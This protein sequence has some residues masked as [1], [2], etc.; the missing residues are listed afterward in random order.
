[1]KMTKW[2]AVA[3]MLVM[4]VGC[5]NQEDQESQSGSQDQKLSGAVKIAGSSTVYPVAMAAAEEFSRIHPDVSVTVS[6][7]GSGGGFA[8]YF[9]PGKTDI[10]NASRPIKPSEMEAAKANG[11]E[12][13]ELRVGI[14]AMSMVAN[15]NADWVDSMTFEQLKRIW[16]PGNPPQR[17]NEVDPSWPDEEFELYGPAATSG[18][19]DYFTE[20]VIGKERAHRSD[21]N[22]TEHDNV[23]VQGIEGNPYALGYFGFAYYVGNKD[24]IKALAIDAGDGPVLPSLANAQSDAYPLSRPLFMYVSRKSLEKPQVRAF[25]EFL[26]R[27]SATELISQVGYVPI[28]EEV[29][30]ENLRKIG[31]E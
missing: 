27:Q 23:I 12:P 3:A 8:N 17:W 25:V 5:G 19:F 6:S 31:V 28:T 14:D 22:P 18:T 29:M 1:M 24:R 30:R 26:I 16:G 4:V 15:K 7:T 10:N 20:V 21:Y 2:I 9:I 13:I 11:I